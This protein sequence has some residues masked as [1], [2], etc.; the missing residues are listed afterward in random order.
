MLGIFG[1]L[2]LASRSMQTQMTGVE[3]SGQNLA[4]VN[5]TG[6]S[7]QRVQIATTP[8]LTTSIGQEGTGASAVSIQQLVSNVL[9]NQIQSQ[10]STSGYWNS[11]QSALQ[12]AQDALAEFLSGSS[13][14]GSTSTASDT[15]GTGLSTQLNS[16]FSAFS[17]L[18]SSGSTSNR[19]AAISAGQALAATFNNLDTQFGNLKTSLNSS[20]TSDVTSAN[21]LL[22]GIANL[23]GEISTA[24][25][26][27]GN[28]N[29]LRDARE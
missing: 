3:V 15:S 27:G 25:F 24:E 12:G 4:N 13:A 26:S 16:F 19:Q 20:L 18:S 9:N 8:D 11:Q 28:A 23:N 5:T 17:A 7:R 14:S 6:Y 29:D 1:T 22:T 21:S 2:N 10:S